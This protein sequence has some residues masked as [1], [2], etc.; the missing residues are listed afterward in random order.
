[1]SFGERQLAGAIGAA[2]ARIM[3]ASVVRAELHDIDEMMQ[4][5][6]DASQLIEYSRQLEEKSDQL[7]S[8]SKD[9]KAANAR[10]QEL[11][12][13]KDSF[14]STVSHELRTPL[15][16]IRSFSEI[17]YDSPDM[18]AKQREEFIGIIVKESERL[19]R[20]IDDVLDITTMESGNLEWQMKILDPKDVIEEA[21]AATAGLF[22]QGGDI[23]LQSDLPD[24]LPAVYV[25]ADRL[26]QVLINLI[27]NAAKFC[28]P[29]DGAVWITAQAEEGYLKVSVRDNGI[30]IDPGD[31]E[32]VFER[33]RQ[34]GN[35]MSGKP[36]GSGL[37]L[38]I[39]T[40]IINQFD[41]EIWVE[42]QL[43]QGATFSFRI[44]AASGPGATK[45]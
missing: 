3:V 2:S 45:D 26:T 23:V 29:E 36:R 35:Q 30:G 8:A 28:D 10:L 19:T 11:D 21:I 6:D 16:S 14:V 24:S 27:S 4:I 31:H 15:T 20:L 1:V 40:E 38:P 22:P 42:S 9:L 25:D 33:F 44:P 34:V 5:V 7:E 39:C 37:G 43:K 41:G 32:K 18:P 12:K 17:I 13:L